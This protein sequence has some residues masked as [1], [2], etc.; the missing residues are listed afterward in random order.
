MELEH[1]AYWAIKKLNFDWK[2]ASEKRLLQL[3]ELDEF[4]LRAYENASIYKEKTKKWHDRKILN[5]EFVSGWSG[6]FVVKRVYPHGVVEVEN[7]ETKNTFNV[8]EQR[9]KVYQGGEG[10]RA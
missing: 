8:N 3:N 7:P 9:L 2:V 10:L 6:P 4:R 1:K 5:R